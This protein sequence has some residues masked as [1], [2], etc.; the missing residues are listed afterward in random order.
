M[1]TP[2][3]LEIEVVRFGV[4]RATVLALATTVCGVMAA[5]WLAYPRPVPMSVSLLCAVGVVAAVVGALPSLRL[6]PIALRRRG[7]LWQLQRGVGPSES[8]E[9]MIA[10]DLGSFMLLRFIPD[11]ARGRARW[12][13][14]QRRGLERQWH[15]LRCAVHA[16]RP[17]ARTG[18]A[19]TDG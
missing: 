7:G 19:T 16:P 9:V 1:R 10:L 14:L 15:E 5:W 13:A 12:V 4:W 11:A 17:R 8:G 6:P 3:P 18:G 2:P